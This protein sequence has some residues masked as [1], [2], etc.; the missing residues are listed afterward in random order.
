M[1]VCDR[2]FMIPFSVSIESG[3]DEEDRTSIQ[4]R[5]NP[6]MSFIAS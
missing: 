2:R 4:L 3:C 5:V 6:K 1:E